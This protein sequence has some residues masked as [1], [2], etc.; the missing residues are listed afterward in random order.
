MLASL[1]VMLAKVTG[2]PNAGAFWVHKLLA[3]LAN[4]GL[5]FCMRLQGI[6]IWGCLWSLR[7]LEL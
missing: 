6:H 1:V 5:L 2:T 4:H 7:G 3:R